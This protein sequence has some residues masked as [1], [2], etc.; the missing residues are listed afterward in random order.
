MHSNLQRRLSLSD[1]ASAAHLSD[2]HFLRVFRQ[3]HGVTPM[4]YLRTQRTRRALALLDSTQLGV[5]E[6]AHT[7]TEQLLLVGQP[8]IHSNETLSFVARAG[9]KTRP[10]TSGGR[11]CANGGPRQAQYGQA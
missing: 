3:V 8:E 11:N 10:P 5:S 7:S 6:V 2:F 1:I 4:M 9:L